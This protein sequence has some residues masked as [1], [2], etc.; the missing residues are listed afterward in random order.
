M[1]VSTPVESGSG[2]WFYVCVLY[3][4]YCVQSSSFHAKETL[5]DDIKLMYSDS[6]DHS[7]NPIFFGK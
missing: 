4:L 6:L 2:A 7:K 1:L 5:F 3:C